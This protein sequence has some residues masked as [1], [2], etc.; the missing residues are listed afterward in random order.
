MTEMSEMLENQPYGRST[1]GNPSAVTDT[2]AATVAVA[3]ERPIGGWALE[4][5]W[6]GA[7]ADSRAPWSCG[8]CRSTLYPQYDFGA[9]DTLRMQKASTARSGLYRFAEMLPVGPSP[10][11]GKMSGD[12]PLVH[13]ERLGRELGLEDLWLKLECYGWPTYSY[14]DRVVAIAVQRAVEQGVRRVACVST[15]NVGNAVA[16]LAAASGLE[17]V[18]FYPEDIEPGKI[19]MS[20]AHGARVVLVRGSFDDANTLCR[21]LAVQGA[22]T[23]VNLDLR[24]F[25]A[26]GAKTIAFELA[27]DFGWYVP[28]HVV[29][30]VAGAALLTRCARGFR[31][32]ARAGLVTAGPRL[33][34]AQPE[35][36]APIASAF[37]SGRSEI[38]PCI[39]DTF[40]KSLAIG[41]PS[42]G[43][44][45]IADLSETSGS[46]TI[47]P[48]RD[49]R[50]AVDLLARTEGI[51][52]EPA[53]G[54][55]VAAARQL[56]GNG[57]VNPSRPEAVLDDAQRDEMRMAR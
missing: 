43:A 5:R 40:A 26:E 46:A 23:F 31:H 1:S 11:V 56:R 42:D 44:S 25:Y 6:H 10:A 13:A 22:L 29:L 9:I 39:P 8:V 53:G 7:A 52:T 20:V 30:P 36:S 50:S 51:L 19:K 35:G 37:R 14:K 17:S 49:I 55:V 18:I 33:H 27:R 28:D 41:N 45:A 54:T 15:G 32:L 12:T 34:A 48:E 3:Q 24:P 4:C 47:V 57:S 16:A 2:S 21:D 38:V